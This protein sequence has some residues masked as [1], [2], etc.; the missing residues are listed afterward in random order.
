MTPPENGYKQQIIPHL[1]TGWHDM[2]TTFNKISKFVLIW[3]DCSMATRNAPIFLCMLCFLSIPCFAQLDN[4]VRDYEP[5]IVT[6]NELDIFHGVPFNE[7]FVYRYTK[8]TDEWTQIPFQFDDVNA[9]KEYFDE[10]DG[11]LDEDDELS[12]MAEDMGDQATPGD[13]IL[14][15]D[16]RSYHRYEIRT[17]DPLTSNQAWIY[18]YRSHSLTI[19]FTNDYIDST[20]DHIVSDI[21]TLGFLDNDVLLDELYIST[22][23]G[24]NN[25]NFLDREKI[26]INGTVN[27]L[28]YELTEEALTSTV[29]IK[30]G[31]V[32][33]I[34]EVNV[35]L[36]SGPASHQKA[37]SERYYRYSSL[38][39][40]GLGAIPDHF[41]VNYMR[42]SLDLNSTA[43][44]MTFSSNRNTGIHIDGQNATDTIEDDLSGLNTIM[45]QITGSPGTVVQLV[46]LPNIGNPQQLYFYD[47]S[48]SGLSGDG[49]VETGDGES[50]GDAG[51]AF[52]DPTPGIYA[53]G[54]Y[55]FFMPANQD[56]TLGETL[57]SFVEN[58]LN[59]TAILKDPYPIELS[60]FSAQIIEAKVKLLWTTESESENLGFNIYRTD[61]YDGPYHRLNHQLIAGA[62]NSSKVQQYEFIDNNSS[63]NRIYYYRLSDIDLNGLETM[64]DPIKVH[65]DAPR[66]FRLIGNYPNPFNPETTVR[67]SLANHTHTT[68]VIYDLIGRKINT[69]VDAELEA[70]YHTIRWNGTDELGNRQSTGIYFC[71]MIVKGY[72][73]TIKMYLI[74]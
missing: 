48:T 49:T 28:S 29:K 73:Q 71:H 69:L 20:A 70:G 25:T 68:L 12:F 6:G 41:G 2:C 65:V 1:K 14:D 37:I 44:G 63:I 64:H 51:I 54:F 8:S 52:Y 60:S 5:V 4:L 40:S 66:S 7:L 30:D 22:T 62:V 11:I 57:M 15:S 27:A 3:M 46:T 53:A 35:R 16:S 19:E 31:P 17:T 45:G 26:R 13:W 38:T 67:F 39:G 72:K 24:G 56:R 21:Y 10:D 32:R 34:R 50:W 58:P 18:I 42:H 33:V 61:D 43:N 36:S 47:H 55:R 23:G 9:N 59:T 74:K